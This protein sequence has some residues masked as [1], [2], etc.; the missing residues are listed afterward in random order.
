MVGML[1]FALYSK[2]YSLTGYAFLGSLGG[3]LA[4][5]LLR[6]PLDRIKQ[7]MQLENWNNS[8][9]KICWSSYAIT[10]ARDIPFSVIQYPLFECL[11]HAQWLTPLG[12][13]QAAFGGGI[14]G[15][16]AAV[17]T[18]PLDFLRT[19]FL[20][21]NDSMQKSSF[22]RIQQ[23]LDKEGFRLLFSGVLYR[24]GWISNGGFIFLGSYDYFLKIFYT[25]SSF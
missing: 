12:S 25:W 13:L 4:T 20:N 22:D 6:I 18:A 19:R 7:R 5:S 11:K 24:I 2:I 1:F 17:A 15:G 14:A 3:E 8:N 10:I 23:I 9:K 16:I 21:Q